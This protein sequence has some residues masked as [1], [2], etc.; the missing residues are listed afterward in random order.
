MSK[1]GLL[2]RKKGTR[3]DESSV[4]IHRHSG[5]EVIPKSKLIWPGYKLQLEWSFDL[6]AASSEDSRCLFDELYR[7][8]LDHMMLVDCGELHIDIS[9]PGITSTNMVRELIDSHPDSALMYIARKTVARAT[10]DADAD[11]D[12]DALPL[13]KLELVV[14]HKSL[15]P[16]L[17][18][19]KFWSYKVPV[20]LVA[21]TTSSDP[22]TVLN[23][24]KVLTRE[25]GEAAP[26]TRQ[27]T[28]HV[29][30]GVDNTGNVRV[31]QAESVL[32][33]HLLKSRRS[34]LKQK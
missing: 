8:W 24:F 10:A 23:D 3:K 14:S 4:S 30:Y 5:F 2:F 32:L 25:T 6:S 9:F 15:V 11:T 19:C 22:S 18:S 20:A 12:T 29:T 13:A 21:A 17:S 28:A 33:Y 16:F 34:Y 26:N 31:W 7:S 1:W 27:L